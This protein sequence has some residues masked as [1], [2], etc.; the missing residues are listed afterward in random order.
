MENV[1]WCAA[2]RKPPVF[3]SFGQVELRELTDF[4]FLK[5]IIQ[6]TDLKFYKKVVQ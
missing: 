6:E 5:K 4:T 2:M 1:L 3:P